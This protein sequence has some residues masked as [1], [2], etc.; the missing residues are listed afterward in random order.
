MIAGRVPRRFPVSRRTV[1]WCVPAHGGY[2]SH[3]KRVDPDSGA[4]DDA[5]AAAIE[6]LLRETAIRVE[7]RWQALAALLA[8]TVLGVLVALIARRGWP[9]RWP[10][11]ALAALVVMALSI[12]LYRTAAY[13][14]NP[15]LPL[16][17]TGWAGKR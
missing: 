14:L 8:A 1:G 17:A 12:A 3:R 11:L 10:L 5:H 4:R 6:G 7:G 9:Q 2:A 13:Y 15:A 16:A